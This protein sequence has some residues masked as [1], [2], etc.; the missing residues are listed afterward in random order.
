M[1]YFDPPP[2]FLVPTRLVKGSLRGPAPHPQ[3]PRLTAGPGLQTV[4]RAPTTTGFLSPRLEP[5][6]NCDPARDAS[7]RGAAGPE[8]E[9]G[10]LARPALG[11]RPPKWRA[12]APRAERSSRS[13]APPAHAPSPAGISAAFFG[14]CSRRHARALLLCSPLCLLRS[15]PFSSPAPRL[16]FSPWASLVQD[17]GDLSESGETH[18]EA[19][20]GGGPGRTAEQQPGAL[21]RNVCARGNLPSPGV[22]Q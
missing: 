11:S 4:S 12:R 13:P 14:I 21:L 19:G 2:F 18:G 5:R 20:G 9:G 6:C 16:P 10:L 3:S 7:L 15:W 1:V 22:C 17:A 8:E